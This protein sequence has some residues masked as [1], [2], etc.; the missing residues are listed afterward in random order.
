MPPFGWA[1]LIFTLSSIPGTDYPKVDVPNADKIVHVV[2][3]A[4]L[5][6]LTARAAA[7]AGERPPANSLRLAIAVV[8]GLLYGASDEFHQFWVPF[9]TPSYYDWAADSLGVLLGVVLWALSQSRAAGPQMDDGSTTTG[10]E[11]A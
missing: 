10:V 2:L 3:Y 4:L 5:G 1:L 6:W 9:R 8:I 11:S 7:S